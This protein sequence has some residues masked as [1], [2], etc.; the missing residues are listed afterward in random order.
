MALV[1]GALLMMTAAGAFAQTS[2][3]A[4]P[5]PTTEL[6][7]EQE[8]A[9][10]QRLREERE[11]DVRSAQ[12]AASQSRLPENESPCFYVSRLVIAQEQNLAGATAGLAA[13]EPNP[14]FSW[15]MESTSG[16]DHTDSPVGKCLG[17]QGIAMVLSRAQESLLQEGFVTT[18]VLAQPQDVSRGTLAIPCWAAPPLLRQ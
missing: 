13:Y 15:L 7:R 8:R 2:A 17:T 11:V 18:R 12:A 10:T 6:R 4:I 5:D 16:P 3:P 14:D 1:P 9:N